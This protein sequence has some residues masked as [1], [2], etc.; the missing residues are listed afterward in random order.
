MLSILGALALVLASAGAAGG[1]AHARLRPRVSK[2]YGRAAARYTTLGTWGP[3][4]WCWFG[5]PRAVRVAVPDD[6]TFVGWIDRQGFIRIGAYDPVFGVMRT[7]VLGRLFHDDHGSPAI[8]VEPDKRLTV[9]WSGHNGVSMNY[10]T[11]LR[12][13]D[14]GAWGPVHRV[15]AR[16]RGGLGFTYPNPVLLPA[17]RDKLYLFWRGADWSADYAMRTLNGRWTPARELIRNPGQRPY[18]KVDGN[19]RDTIALAFTEAHPRD[20]LTSVYYAV[21]RGGALWG[22]DGRR[23]ALMSALPIAPRQADVVYDARKTGVASWVWDV[24]LN[25]GDPV[26]VYATF[27]TAANHVYWYARWNG[28]QW[29]SHFM[30]FAGPSISPGTIEYEYS[31]GMALDHSDPSIVYLSRMVRGEFEIEKWNTDDGGNSWHERTL[32]RGGAMYN[33][34]PVVV[35][36]ADGGPMSLLWLRGEYG[37]YTSYRTSI[38]FLH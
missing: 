26:I 13:E 15:V 7:H 19:G 25:R 17:E 18:L 37:S 9:F 4:S 20:V 35:R 1:G 14:I 12:P 27:P 8:L 5:D 38:E 33:V 3:G 24:A 10:R 23:I 32:V 29:V 34:R 22:A 11:T 21:Y 16:L 31:G 36:G 2:A 28:R 6:E 30:T